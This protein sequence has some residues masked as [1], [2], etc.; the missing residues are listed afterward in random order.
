MVLPRMDRYSPG[1]DLSQ[2]CEACESGYGDIG[3]AETPYAIRKGQLIQMI[4]LLIENVLKEE[5]LSLC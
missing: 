2:L 1:R 5:E 3:L 4:S